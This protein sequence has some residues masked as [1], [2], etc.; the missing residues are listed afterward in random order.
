MG[1]VRAAYH[2]AF[3]AVAA[4]P[5]V[6]PLFL[7]ETN[8][9]ADDVITVDPRREPGQLKA[10]GFEAVLLLPNS[11]RAAWSARRAGI[12]ERWGYAANLRWPLLTRRVSIGSGLECVVSSRSEVESRSRRA[13][14][15]EIQDLTPTEVEIQ[16]LTPR[17]RHQAV[18]YLNLVRALG[19]PAPPLLPRVRVRPQTASRAAALLE[20][21]GVPSGATIVGV[22]PGAA[23]GHAK[24]W[25]PARM[26]ELITRLSRE[27]GAL[28]ILLGAAGD[29]ES[30]RE[31]ESAL[32]AGASVVNLIGRTELRLFAGV[33]AHC[34]AFVS[35]DSGAMHLAAAVGVPV[36]AIFGPTDERVTAPLGDHD[37]LLHQVF[38]R[39]CM[40]RE[41][42]IDHRCMKGVS[43]D[44]VFQAVSRRLAVEA[45]S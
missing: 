20:Q 11:F 31:I 3:V 12:P 29:R 21:A 8:A 17:R 43:V 25:P 40:L 36:A 26:A 15:V 42:P 35:N 4:V 32:P 44:A 16:D 34:R 30:G 2:D 41:C 7:E 9:G 14:E 22:A 6:A 33:L 27:R 37:V 39:P 24:R 1:A 5:S 28:C 13:V 19:M 45:R 10:G 38:C 18:Y 23:Y